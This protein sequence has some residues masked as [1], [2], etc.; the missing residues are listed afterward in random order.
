M[1]GNFGLR[2]N[3]QYGLFYDPGLAA[4]DG[5]SKTADLTVHIGR[6]IYIKLTEGEST[7]SGTGQD[8]SNRTANTA[9][10]NNQDP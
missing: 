1:D 8:D 7:D 3:P 5:I 2:V 10:S 9:A 4:A 6:V